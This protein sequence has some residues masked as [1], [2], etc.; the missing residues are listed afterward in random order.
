MWS[1]EFSALIGTVS[2]SSAGVYEVKVISVGPNTTRVA[3]VRGNVSQPFDHVS[4]GLKASSLWVFLGMAFSALGVFGLL[5]GG[6]FAL[7]RR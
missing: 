7:M 6:L 4:Q 2:A 5:G 1:S 3:G